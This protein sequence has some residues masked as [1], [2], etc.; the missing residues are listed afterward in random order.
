MPANPHDAPNSSFF[1]RARQQ[2]EAFLKNPESLQKLLDQVNARIAEL[3]ASDY[4]IED[5]FRYLASFGRM[6]AAYVS[7]SY[8]E[9]PTNKVILIVA[10]LIYFVSP[11][12]LIPDFIPVVGYLDDLAILTWVFNQLR[13]EVAAFERW[14]TGRRARRDATDDIVDRI[15]REE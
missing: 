9:L 15:R 2:A 14:E 12:D 3:R 5:L 4:R 11:I 6:M 7:G 8:R 13:D 10:G 1:R